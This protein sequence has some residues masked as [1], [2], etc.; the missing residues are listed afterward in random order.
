ME[1]TQPA[2]SEQARLWNGPSGHA[3]VDAQATL[4]HLFRPI[5]ALLAETARTAGARRVLDVGCGTGATTLAVASALGGAG[6]CTGIDISQPMIATARERAAR[7]GSQATFVCADARSHVFA[8]G[9][10]DLLVSRF[11][12]MFFDDPVGAFAN[13]HRAA[14]RDASVR[15][16]AWRSAAENL[17]MTT[18]E[19]AAAPLLPKLQ[20]RPAG[21][22]GQFAFADAER[23]RSILK[24]SGWHDIAIEP[25]DVPCAMPEADLAGYLSRLGPV[26]GALREADAQ[27]RAAVIDVVRAAFEPFVHGEEVRFVAA[28]WSIG[29]R[30]EGP[31]A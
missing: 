9:S 19:H 11:G 14:A 24:D 28:C 1:T 8:P 31:A 23:V 22:P 26:G 18:A 25:I 5:E 12:V 10:F 13:L 6:H 15:F 2:G 17:F 20:P 7:Q 29:A 27:T 21:G 3:W 30:A 4:D 16:I